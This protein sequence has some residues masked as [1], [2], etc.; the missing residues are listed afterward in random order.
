M[1]FQTI[2]SMYLEMFPVVP[3]GLQSIQSEVKL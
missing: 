2:T 1:V 3:P